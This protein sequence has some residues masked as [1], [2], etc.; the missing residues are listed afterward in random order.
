MSITILGQDIFVGL[1]MGGLSH[2]LPPVSA[3]IA[4]Q[5]YMDLIVQ[6]T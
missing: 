6:L 3:K 5:V 2:I 4:L 1:A